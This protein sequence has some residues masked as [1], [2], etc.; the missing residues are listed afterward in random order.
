VIGQIKAYRGDLKSAMKAIEQS[1]Q[2]AI[3]INFKLIILLN[4]WGKAVILEFD[5]KWEE[6]RQYYQELVTFWQE[7]EDR[8]DVLGGICAAVTFFADHDHY[9]DLS[10]CVSASASIAEETGNPESIGVLSYS[11]GMSSLSDER[12]E[13]ARK[14]FE[15]AFSLFKELEVPL[16][17]IMTQCQLGK[18]LIRL[19]KKEAGISHLKQANLSAKK[20]GMRPIS[21]KIENILKES[22]EVATD[23]RD[24]DHSTRKSFGGLTSR[25]FEILQALSEGLSNKEIASRL[26][27]STRTVDMHVRN[28][29]DTLNCRNRADAVKVAMDLG[30]LD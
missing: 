10:K 22:G 30:I 28:V 15:K 25:Q 29:F 8:H 11:L 19:N 4:L 9:E 7:S 17:M 26:F 14:N 13:E 18:V 6:S 12:L 3:R 2:I 27:L 16:Q 24:M 21:S 23:R 1:N 5:K 20:L